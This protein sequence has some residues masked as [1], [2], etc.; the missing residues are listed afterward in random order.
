MNN[1]QAY[2]TIAKS[3]KVS[4][5]FLGTLKINWDFA[6]IGYSAICTESLPLTFM[7]KI[8][9]GIVNLDGR[10][11]LSDLAHI[12]GLN[13]ENDVQNLKFQD[14]GETEILLDTLR[15]LKQFGVIV[16]PDSSFSYVELTEI[17][18]EYYAKGRKFKHGET[19][20]FT[21][22]FD[23]TAGK[24]S[25]ARAMF[26]KLTVDGSK[27]QQEVAQIPY[28]DE[29]F[30][31]QYAESQIPQYYSEE[32]GNS[33]TNMCVTSSEFLYKEVVLGVLYDSLTETYR[34]EIIDNGGIDS[35]C[36]SDYVN[37]EENY[38]HYLN[39]FLISQP[40]T[41]ETKSASQIKF[42]EEIAKVQSDAEYAI[43]NEKPE[44]AL[45]LVGSYAKSPEYM[46]IQNIFNFIKSAI[47]ADS[48]NNIFISFPKLT[49]EI[50][51]GIRTLAEEANT[52]IMLSCEDVEDFDSRFGDKVLALNGNASSDAFL[53]MNDVAYGC[54]DLVFSINDLKFEH[55]FLHKQE[56]NTEDALEQIRELY[57]SKFIPYELDQYDEVLEEADVAI[58]AET[59]IDRI[60]V[61][62]SADDLVKFD[63]SYIILTGNVERLDS[64]RTQRDKQLLELVLNY[65]AILMEELENLRANISL[66][67]IK[68][69]DA[70]EQAQNSLASF[71]GKLIP[72][73]YSDN[74]NGWGR[75]GVA[76]VLNESIS[77]FESE[78]MDHERYLR[79]ELLPK[80][81][82][83]D[84]NVFVH[85]PEIMDY[86]GKQ[87]RIILSLKVLDELDK[88]KVTLSGKDKRNVKK[89]IKEINNKI[90]M[91]SKTFS[92]ESGDTRLLPEEY[93]KTTPDNLIL[94]V[95]LKFSNRNP[96]LVTNDINFQNRAASMGIPFKG[97]VDLLPKDVYQSIDFTQSDNKMLAPKAIHNHASQTKES[98]MPKNLSKIFKEAYLA[99]KEDSDEVLLAK[100]ASMI[101]EINPSF[102]PNFFGYTKFKELCMAYPS[103]IELYENSDNALCVR[104]M[105][106]DKEMSSDSKSSK[107]EDLDLLND[108]QQNMLKELLIK[109]INEE[110]PSIPTSDGEIRKAFIKKSG[111][112]IKLKPVIQMRELLGIPSAKQRKINYTN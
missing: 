42:E 100:F 40:L 70:I 49:E 79:Q 77:D 83:I 109:M 107:I 54:E 82:I 66:E 20:G 51:N 13:I 18:K 76:L 1:I 34:F 47:K 39:L 50:E 17:G 30:V 16:T 97:L 91:K 67:D 35:G 3:K 22:Y 38:N 33:F 78:L 55:K 14:M 64:L 86:L 52:S 87:D 73:Q 111:L 56:R 93:D 12:M 41:S 31:K 61:L 44:L 92:M 89:A 10:V 63:E 11:A 7:E 59:I 60:A 21:M 102:R 105:A 88:L 71:K 101:R 104:M 68:T 65:S 103:V 28:A 43:F 19:K 53:M 23:L 112:Q 85:F 8:V 6:K 5:L 110:A 62:K 94:S 72:E 57:A 99:C 46:E 2:N 81:Y 32:T 69:L 96:F 26:S 25:N 80:S 108:E 9:C 24:H 45:Q 48:N 84:T 29:S 90:R 4:E 75:T 98:A 36:I 95:A 15:T 27:E 74:E 37:L 58:D 106:W